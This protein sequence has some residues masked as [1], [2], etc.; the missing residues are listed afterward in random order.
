MLPNPDVDV[1]V[2]VDK[3]HIERPKNGAICGR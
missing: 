1:D 2:D 3:Y